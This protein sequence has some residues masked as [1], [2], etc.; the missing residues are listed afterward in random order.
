MLYSTIPMK[1]RETSNRKV[2][3]DRED[4]K[5]K[6]DGFDQSAKREQKRNFWA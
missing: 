4:K 3:P 5:R 1:G 6:K 2:R